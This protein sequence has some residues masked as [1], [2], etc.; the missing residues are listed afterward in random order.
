MKR[1]HLGDAAIAAALAALTLLVTLYFAPR[2]FHHGF[3]DMAHDGYQLRQAL[4]LYQGGVIFRDTFD[5]YGPLTAYINLL[6]FVAF[7]RR[8]MAMKILIALSYGATAVLLYL[9]AR[10]LLGR[11]LSAFSVAAWLALA[12][13]YQHGIMISA[14]AYLLPVQAVALLVMFRFVETGRLALLILVGV[15]CGVGWM[16]KQSFGV[17]FVAGIALSMLLVRRDGDRAG[18]LAV[19][20]GTLAAAFA[21]VVGVTLAWLAAAGALRDWYLQTVVFPGE[22]YVSSSRAAAGGAGAILTHFLRLQWEVS[23]VWLYLRLLLFAGA[24][25]AFRC[26]QDRPLIVLACVTLSLWL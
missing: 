24:V 15:L 20:I 17:L 26:R 4:D 14:H 8:L 21:T 23:G 19:E 5:Q 22:F 6:G 9:L 2:G 7:G 11:P 25:I 13:F 1:A 3:V 18:R 12:P 10:R 16:L